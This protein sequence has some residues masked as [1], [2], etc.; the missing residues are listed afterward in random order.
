MHLFADNNNMSVSHLLLALLVI[1]IWGINFIFVKFALD[2][3]P[4]LLLCAVRFFMASAPAI[5]FVKLPLSQIKSVALY[6]FITFALQFSLLFTGMN[7]GMTPGLASLILQLQVFFSIFFAALFLSEKPYLWQIG[8]A[9]IAFAGIILIATHL[10]SQTSTLGFILILAASAS[11]GFGNLIVKKSNIDMP[12]LIIWGS[13]FAFLPTLAFSLFFEGI[14]NITASYQ[15][16][17]WKGIVS[18]LYIVFASTWVAYGLWNWLLKKYTVSAIVPFTLLVPIVAMISSTL[19][20]DEPMEL[21]K[22]ISGTL[23]ISGLCISLFGNRLFIKQT[24]NIK[25]AF[26]TE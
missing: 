15:Q 7:V 12:V 6:G 4:P 14:D 17:S 18:M 24:R 16:L 20:L 8:G 3:M 2:E 9:I 1:L 10:D 5:L 26:T 25:T 21:W 11:W 19:I 22:I 23:V 13:F